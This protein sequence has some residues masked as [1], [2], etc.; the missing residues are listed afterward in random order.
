MRFQTRGLVSRLVGPS[1]YAWDFA[2]SV[3]G[4]PENSNLKMGGTKCMVELRVQVGRVFGLQDLVE[5]GVALDN[6]ELS[7]LKRC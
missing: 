1:H 5:T 3:W 4:Y 2:P 7:F 6:K